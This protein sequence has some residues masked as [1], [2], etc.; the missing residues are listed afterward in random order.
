MSSFTSFQV[1]YRIWKRRI[2]R[3]CKCL[4]VVGAGAF[5]FWAYWAIREVTEGGEMMHTA[6][7]SPAP[8]TTPTPTPTGVPNPLNTIHIGNMP[9]SELAWIVGGGFVAVI[10]VAAVAIPALTTL[11]GFA[12]AYEISRD[13]GK[14]AARRSARQ[15]RPSIDPKKAHWTE[16]ATRIGRATR[17]WLRLVLGGFEDSILIVGPSRAWKSVWAAHNVLDAPGPVVVT[18]T[19]ISEYKATAPVR[20]K[21]GDALLFN[22]YKLG[23][24]VSTLRWSPVIGCED[25]NVALDRA[26]WLL[27]GSRKDSTSLEDFFKSTAADVLRAYLHAAALGDF[28]VRSVL[29]WAANPDDTTPISIL[30][31]YQADQQWIDLL[32]QRQATTDRTRDGIFTTLTTALGW[33]ADPA[34]AWTACPSPSENFDM[35]KFLQGRNTLY[36]LAENKVG[37]SVAPLF[38]CFISELVKVAKQVAADNGGRLDPTLLLLLDEV[39]NICPVPLPAYF[40][41][42]PGQGILPVAAIQSRSQLVEMWGQPGSKTVWNNAAWT[43]VLAGIK[44]PDDLRDLSLLM[45]TRPRK[46]T[47]VTHGPQGQTHSYTTEDVD[48]MAP[49]Q[50]RRLRRRRILAI[51]RG[52]SPVVVKVKKSWQ[53]ADVRQADADTR[54]ANKDMR[55]EER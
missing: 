49:S 50:I 5:G 35:L 28:D 37:S 44:D 20:S 34:V 17:P 4:V 31:E 47:A 51:Y 23:K 12:S 38:T 52:A 55:K 13:L 7:T 8:H 18:S 46:R 1:V 16:Y 32:R 10:A 33:L 42:L 53:R 9:L 29:S 30:E 21:F 2:I 6:S 27:Y 11:P 24:L 41:E 39:A 26:A 25:P 40:S 22:P 3:T 36:M 54:Q 43:L 14:G 48:V 15:T 19:K 45:G